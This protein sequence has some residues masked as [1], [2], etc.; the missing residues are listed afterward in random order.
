MNIRNKHLVQRKQWAKWSNGAR[1][2]FNRVFEEMSDQAQFTH[3]KAKR[4]AIEHWLTT[5][6]NAAW[7]AADHFDA[8]TSPLPLTITIAS[9]FQGRSPA[10][11]AKR[12]RDEIAKAFKSIKA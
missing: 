12:L 1:A 7:I 8:I 3:P 5:S 11:I 10:Q 9:A 2:M 6:W 4:V